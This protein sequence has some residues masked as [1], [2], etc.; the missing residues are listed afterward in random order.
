MLKAAFERL[1]DT[2]EYIRMVRER[3][4]L[5]VW[6]LRDDIVRIIE[7][8]QVSEAFVGSGGG[9]GRASMLLILHHD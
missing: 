4:S 2:E 6:N 8:N 5:P 1:Q 9:R 7:G 3:S